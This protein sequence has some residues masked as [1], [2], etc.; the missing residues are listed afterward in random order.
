[1]HCIPNLVI[2][3]KFLPSSLLG[4]SDIPSIFGIDGPKISASR[5]PTLYFNFFKAMAKLTE[6]VDL[7]TPPFALET[8]II[9]LT[10]A[11]GSFNLVVPGEILS[12]N[13]LLKLT[14]FASICSCFFLLSA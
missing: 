10:P 14:S 4:F 12:T 13:S 8:A 2:G 9:F 1:M 7:P 3:I 11:I 6:I 5:I